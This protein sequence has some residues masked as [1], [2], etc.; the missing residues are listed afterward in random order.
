MSQRYYIESDIAYVSPVIYGA[1]RGEGLR[2]AIVFAEYQTHLGLTTCCAR[3]L[4]RFL[5]VDCGTRHGSFELQTG[6]LLE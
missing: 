4:R 1:S 3:P 6:R 5:F 2:L